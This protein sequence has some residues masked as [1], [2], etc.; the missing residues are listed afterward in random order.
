MPRSGRSLAAATRRARLA[1]PTAAPS[2]GGQ[3][4]A[5]RRDDR[6]AFKGLLAQE[7]I[8]GMGGDEK[9]AEKPAAKPTSRVLQ[10]TLQDGRKLVGKVH[11]RGD[12][13]VVD[14][15]DGPVQ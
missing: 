1:V 5:E 12:S 9:P 4:P 3:K 7:D 14:T 11:E 8:P 13:L 2:E 10:V 6:R 15:A